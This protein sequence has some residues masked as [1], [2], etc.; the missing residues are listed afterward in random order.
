MPWLPCEVS[1][2]IHV[3]YRPALKQ[4]VLLGNKSY[5]PS[6]ILGQKTTKK[7]SRR[8]SPLSPFPH[9]SLMERT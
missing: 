3:F 1:Q 7:L 4:P 9:F 6:G 8:F 5:P 2:E